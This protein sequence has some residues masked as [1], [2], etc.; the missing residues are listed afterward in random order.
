MSGK[1]ITVKHARETRIIESSTLWKFL[2]SHFLG[3]LSA[4]FQKNP[5]LAC[6]QGVSAGQPPAL[7]ARVMFRATVMQPR[8]H[9]PAYG[10]GRWWLVGSMS[11]LIKGGANPC[12]SHLGKRQGL[13]IEKLASDWTAIIYGFYF[14]DCQDSSMCSSDWSHKMH[15]VGTIP[16][17]LQFFFP[18]T[19]F[20][21]HFQEEGSP[22]PFLTVQFGVV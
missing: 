4:I 16:A 7:G 22:P 1:E 10:E 3:I 9:P 15:H 8:P 17:L 14:N 19:L 11:H 2:P 21:T 12:K 6:G 18:W 5:S 13:L 20:L